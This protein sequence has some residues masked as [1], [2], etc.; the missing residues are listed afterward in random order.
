[1]PRPADTSSGPRTVRPWMEAK[2][3]KRLLPRD[4]GARCR[5]RPA[6]PAGRACPP[7]LGVPQALAIGDPVRPVAWRLTPRP[8][9]PAPEIHVFLDS[10]PAR[11]AIRSPRQRA[12]VARRCQMGDDMP[13]MIF[14]TDN[15]QDRGTREG[16]QFEFFCRHCG[17]GYTSSFQH[18]V[19]GFGGRLL[20]IGGDLVG[21]TVGQTASQ[22]GWDAEWMRDGLRG[23]ARERRAARGRM[24]RA[25]AP[26]GILCVP[27]TSSRHATVGRHR[28]TGV[29]TRPRVSLISA[30]CLRPRALP[31]GP[32]T[33]G[34]PTVPLTLVGGG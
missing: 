33:A 8:R 5:S 7:G 9:P 10:R 1:M 12:R 23:S 13:E 3:S 14:F 30:T 16:Y 28:H 34:C 4:V 20:R 11:E 19:T 25:R 21:G 26:A 6:P 2:G 29:T 27:I 24:I 17:N 22:V 31:P 18:S 32:W 15:Y